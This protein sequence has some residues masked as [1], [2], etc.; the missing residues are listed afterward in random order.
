LLITLLMDGDHMGKL[1]GKVAL[2][3]GATSGIGEATS[4][5]F[6]SEG[7]RV[8]VVGR[9]RERGNSV[10]EGICK[11]GEEA[12]F[13]CADV[14]KQEASK[15]MI[16]GTVEKYGTL[17]ILFN[18]AGFEGR[19]KPLQNTTLEEWDEVLDLHLKSLF[20]SCKFA[21]PHM[22]KNE[23]GSIINASSELGVGFR[24]ASN[25]VSYATSKAAVIAFTKALAVETASKNIRVNCVCPGCINTPMIDREVNEWVKQ[26]IYKDEDQAR[27]TLAAAYPVG[28]IGEVSDIAQAVLYLA[29]DDAKFVT[30]AALSIDG[31]GALM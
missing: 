1:T 18:N 24:F 22:I 8:C 4:K 31:G 23:V 9:N 6:A 27:D 25:Y 19:V 30:G 29:S 15:Q 5:L 10:V 21:I 17:D 26:G 12:F 3:T 7:A 14:T 2:I 13:F 20:L 16:E 28:H 11:R